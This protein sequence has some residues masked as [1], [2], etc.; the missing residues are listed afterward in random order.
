MIE[1]PYSPESEMAVIASILEDSSLMSKVSFLKSDDFY[2]MAHREIYALFESE[3]SKGSEFDLFTIGHK[4]TPEMGD[5]AYLADIMK[6]KSAPKRIV[7]YGK[8]VLDLSIRRKAMEF[9]SNGI[10]ALSDSS[11]ELMDG[12]TETSRGVDDNISRLAVG[13]VFTVEQLIDKSVEEMEESLREARLGISTGI[14]EIDERLGYQ[15]LAIGELTYLGAQSKNGKTLFANTIAARCDLEENE[16][17]HI[18]SIEMPAIRMFNG[19]VS[20]I[21]G[22]P[23]DFYA[24]Q[25][26]YSRV[27]AKKYDEWMGKW[28][29]AAQEINNSGRITIDDRKDVT[30]SYICAEIRKQYQLMAN[31]GKVLRLVVIDHLHRISFDT[32][33]KPMT[34]AMGDDARMLKNTAAELGVAVLLLGQLNENCKDRDPTAFDILD[35]SRLRHEIQCFI[36]TRIFRQDGGTYFGIY[37]DAHRY[38]DHETKFTPGY[39]KMIGGVVKSLDEG[40]Y[41]NPNSTDES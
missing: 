15:N 41:F 10:A 34:Y 23:S 22:V 21:S 25:S 6:T 33:K 3:T 30:M 27:L 19:V 7:S 36:G 17:C 20:A 2:M 29:K 16:C 28:G 12:I 18:F 37:S 24:R 1:P 5:T 11:V 14:A 4:I 40:E 32:S 26:Y 13:D 38:A 8:A 31:A 35:T 39:M 9:Y